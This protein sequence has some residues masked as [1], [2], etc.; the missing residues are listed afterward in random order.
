VQVT[1]GVWCT[2]ARMRVS[3]RSTSTG[4]TSLTFLIERDP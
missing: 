2:L 4:W 1:T 3:A